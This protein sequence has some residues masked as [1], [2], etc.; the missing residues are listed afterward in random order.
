MDELME[1]IGK[2]MVLQENSAKLVNAEYAGEV[3]AIIREASTDRQRIEKALDILLD[4]AFDANV[5][6]I[7]RKLC[8]YYY[9][10]APQATC[11]YIQS[12]RELWDNEEDLKNE[13]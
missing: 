13:N 7:F 4:F 6:E 11:F 3:K 2:L 9:D 8:R 12:Y 5:L 1:E 10:I